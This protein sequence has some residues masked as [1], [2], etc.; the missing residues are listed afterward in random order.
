MKKLGTRNITLLSHGAKMMGTFLEAYMYVEEELYVNEAET[1]E[2][3]CEYID[4][5][6]GGASSYNM[7]KL[8][9]AFINPEDKKAVAFAMG[10]KKKIAEIRG[11]L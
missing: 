9:K 3:F 7:E 4:K 8:F 2:N 6:I 10:V 1:I 5:E 11:T